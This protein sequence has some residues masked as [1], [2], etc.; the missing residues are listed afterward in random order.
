MEYILKHNLYSCRPSAVRKM[1]WVVWKVHA[2]FAEDFEASSS[3]FAI[4]GYFC[5]VAV[6]NM[7]NWEQY[8]F[9]IQAILDL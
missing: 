4:F 1:Y 5:S 3:R 7:S 2:S 8:F 6:F 9:S